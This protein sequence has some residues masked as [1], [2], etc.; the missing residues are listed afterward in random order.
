MNRY[1]SL[2]IV[3]FSISFSCINLGADEQNLSEKFSEVIFN[4]LNCDKD[5]YELINSDDQLKNHFEVSLDSSVE[6]GR[7]ILLHYCNKKDDK[8][9]FIDNSKEIFENLNKESPQ[10]YYINIVHA[11]IKNTKV[12]SKKDLLY[13][14]NEQLLLFQNNIN[15]DFVNSESWD[16]IIYFL[17]AH[18]QQFSNT[19]WNDQDYIDSISDHESISNTYLS[20]LERLILNTISSE[21]S[22]ETLNKVA[23]ILME[24]RV[25]KLENMD[26]YASLRE[27]VA[28]REYFL[29]T[30]LSKFKDGYIEYSEFNEIIRIL[31]N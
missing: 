11:F 13:Q 8:N 1:Y 29:K 15:S 23:T 19:S 5:S 14:L 12:K 17:A 30:Y 24:M 2:V 16:E 9:F 21:Q 31:S 4:N 20:I 18:I 27:I 22:S 10:I 28:E 6:M 25:L 3:V 26:E 7:S